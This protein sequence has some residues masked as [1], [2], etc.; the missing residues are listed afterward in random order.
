M[1]TPADAQ[2]RKITLN[3]YEADAETLTTHYGRGWSTNVRD[4]IHDHANL[5]RRSVPVKT[6]GDLRDETM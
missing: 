4:L 5:I 6:L 1:P 3:L 2:L